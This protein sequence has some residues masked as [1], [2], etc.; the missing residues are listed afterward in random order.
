MRLVFVGP[1]GAGKGTQAENIV[2]KYGLFHLSTGDALR[3]AVKAKTPV[4]IEAEKYMSAGALV[5][6]EVVVGVVVD[7][8]DE[9][10]AGCLLDG[11]P[12]TIAQAEALD[13]ILA[14]KNAPLDVVLELAVPDEELYARLASRGRADDKPEVIK[15]R[16]VAYHTQ[17][18]PL[19]DYYT[20]AGILHKIDGLGTIDE[21]FERIQKVL[22]QFV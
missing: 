7:K 1:P 20:K 9:A 3:A 5:P 18:E 11:F 22:D 14:E 4:G 21:I 6:D 17:T 19:V 13:K 16:L 12:R 15:Q 10:K 8:I 2:A